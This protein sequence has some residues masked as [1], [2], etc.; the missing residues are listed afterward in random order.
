MDPKEL[1]SI[2]REDKISEET[3]KLI[4]S[5]LSHTDSQGQKLCQYQGCWYYYNTLQGVLNFQ[6]GFKPQDTDIILASYP[7]SGTTWL[8]ALTVALLERSKNHS[9]L[10]DDEHPLLYDN[11]HGIVPCLE[12]DLY[13]ESSSPNLSKFSAHRR[14]FST[15]M[16]LQAMHETL[17]HSPCKI[18]YVCR[19]VKDTLVSWWFFLCSILKIEQSRGVLESLHESFCKGIIYY[20]PFWEHLLSYWRASLEDPEHVLFMRY[21]EMKA[22]PRDQIKRLADFLG[23]PFTKQEEDSGV[24]DEVLDLCSLRNLSSLEVNKTGSRNDVDHKFYFRKGEVGDSK[25]YLTPEMEN[26]I[27]MIIKEKLQGSGLI[28]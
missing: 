9:S 17:K 10:S 28:F 16:P 6:R 26:K 1:P 24:V 13:H 21:E 2:L 3:K 14:L 25:N 18:V 4:S 12:M 27:D 19:N 5:L 20:G 11:P 8:K 7:K 22:E 23:C 15:H